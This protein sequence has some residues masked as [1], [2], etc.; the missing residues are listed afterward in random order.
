MSTYDTTELTE[1]AGRPIE[2][3]RFAVGPAVYRYTSAGFEVVKDGE[4]YLPVY[5][6]TRSEPELSKE[7]AQQQLTVRTP[8]DMPLVK[9]FLQDDPGVVTLK[10]FR[11]HEGDTYLTN[12]DWQ[13]YWVGRAGA[14]QLDGEEAQITCEPLANLMKRTGLYRRHQSA[15]Q[16]TLYNPRCGVNR[17]NWKIVT[18]L[19]TVSG[20]TVTAAAFATKPDDWLGTGYLERASGARRDITYHVGSTIK[21]LKPLAGLA[22]GETVTVFAGCR[23]RYLEDCIG[24]FATDGGGRAA[25]AGRQFGGCPHKPKRNPFTDGLEGG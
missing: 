15:C 25:P 13:T 6:L 22:V 23:R 8:R 10:I 12:P 5:P 1:A 14:V 4:R 19:A 16:H 2:I 17:E 20:L 11:I 24:K 7:P 3:Y 18:A 21:L 9:L